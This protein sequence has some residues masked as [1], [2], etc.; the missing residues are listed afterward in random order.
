MSGGL[1]FI[2][3]IFLGK[4]CFKHICFTAVY[5]HLDASAEGDSRLLDLCPDLQLALARSHHHQ[6][7]L[8]HRLRNGQLVFI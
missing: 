2:L 1:L 5:L 8:R 7:Q 6:V 4:T 3:N